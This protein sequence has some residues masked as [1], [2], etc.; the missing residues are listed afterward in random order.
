MQKTWKQIYEMACE[1]L[2]HK[3]FNFGNERFILYRGFRIS[4]LDGEYKWQDVRNDSFYTPVDPIITKH[5]LDNGFFK[6]LTELMVHNDKER[7]Y[8]LNKRADE[9]ERETKGW[10]NKSSE[11]YRNFKKS[12]TVIIENL[13]LTPDQI[14]HRIEALNKKYMRNKNLYAKKRRVLKEERKEVEAQTVFYESR[15]KLYN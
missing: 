6:T 8:Q 3:L 2:P 9:I 7:L 12:E 10:T 4:K 13:N 11:N 15:I 5:I 14:D 1:E